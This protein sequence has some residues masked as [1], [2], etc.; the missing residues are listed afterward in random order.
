M[1]LRLL[2]TDPTVKSNITKS[3]SALHYC[4]RNVQSTKFASV[5]AYLSAGRNL[6]AAKLVLRNMYEI[7][8]IITRH[9]ISKRKSHSPD[10]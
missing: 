9:R 2:Q 5:P 1:L 6:D 3:I 7:R 10:K 4:V 8:K